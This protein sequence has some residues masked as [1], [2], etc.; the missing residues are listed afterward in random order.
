MGLGQLLHPLLWALHPEH[1]MAVLVYVSCDK[2]RKTTIFS[3]DM[4]RICQI[5]S[6]VY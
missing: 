4:P 1:S 2:R 5:N 6:Y 3:T